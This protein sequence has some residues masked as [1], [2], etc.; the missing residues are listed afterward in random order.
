MVWNEGCDREAAGEASACG[1]VRLFVW[2]AD[3]SRAT[4]D[5]GCLFGWPRM[6][7]FWSASHLT[8]QAERRPFFRFDRRPDR[9]SFEGAIITVRVALPTL[10]T[11]D[12]KEAR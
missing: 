11:S 10:D 1:Q 4:D 12:L 2:A 8:R 3:F 6:G 9:Q 5:G 7:W